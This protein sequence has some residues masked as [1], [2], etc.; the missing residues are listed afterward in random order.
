[1]SLAAML[2][3][4]LGD[5]RSVERERVLITARYWLDGISTRCVVLNLSRS[6]AMVAASSPPEEGA[7]VTL[8]CESL[9][10]SA[11]VAW[12]HHYQFGLAFERE[13]DW[14]AVAAIID[15]AGGRGDGR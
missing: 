7:A 3:D 2:R 14:R 8:L 15:V 4:W 5:K 9:E 11:T 13:A 12:V 10:A 1:M 6:G